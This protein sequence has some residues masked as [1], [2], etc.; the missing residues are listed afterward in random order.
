M[1]KQYDPARPACLYV[2][3]DGIQY[4]APNVFDELIDKKEMPA[5][6]CCEP[7]P[8]CEPLLRAQRRPVGRAL[9]RGECPGRARRSAPGK[10][11]HTKA[12]TNRRA[13]GH[14]AGSCGHSDGDSS[15]RFSDAPLAHGHVDGSRAG[16]WRPCLLGREGSEVAR[17]R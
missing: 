7:L 16:G 9:D 8:R 17:A 15:R 2:N 13:H 10:K 1:P 5:P 11:A 12:Y 3:Q 14:L 4:N 6:G